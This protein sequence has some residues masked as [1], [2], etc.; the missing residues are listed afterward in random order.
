MNDTAIPFAPAGRMKLLARET[1][2]MKQTQ[3]TKLLI[4][5]PIAANNQ[6]QDKSRQ[7]CCC[8]FPFHNAT[9]K[10]RDYVFRAMG[11]AFCMLCPCF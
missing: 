8:M 7:K 4:L 1:E 5:I 9:R 2:K 3:L 6:T 10:N 11:I